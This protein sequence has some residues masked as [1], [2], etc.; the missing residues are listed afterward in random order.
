[1]EKCIALYLR[2]SQADNDLNENDKDESN[3]IENQRALL[4]NY[5]ENR[6]EMD[7][8]IQE[9]IDDGYTGTNFDRPSFKRMIEDAKAGK[10][11][12]ILVKDLSRLG[13]DYIGVG[14][15]LEQI[16]PA[17][18]IR[19][20]AVNSNYDS[21]NFIGNTMGIDTSLT[22][23]MNSLFSKD[24]SKKMK[25]AKTALWKKGIATAGKQPYGY[26]R[27][28]SSPHKWVIDEEA[29]SVVRTI[30]RMAASGLRTKDIVEYLNT[31][32]IPIPA[33]YRMDKYG[34]KQGNIR[35]EELLWNTGGVWRIIRNYS[36]T[37]CAVQGKVETISV[38]SKAG[39]KVPED[40]RYYVAGALPP[41]V[42]V[43][44]FEKAQGAINSQKL[45]GKGSGSGNALTGKIRCGN[46]KLTL[47]YKGKND[48]YLYCQHAAISG[49]KSKCNRD[50]YS[51]PVIENQVRCA[52]NNQIKLLLDL[53][54]QLRK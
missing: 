46:C 54:A 9:Y 8:E 21:N 25:S 33:K 38:G 18:N 13:R 19:F 42:T 35:T 2:L 22:N 48:K 51:A 34:E 29:A 7:G 10:I 16:F 39:R 32:E 4:R 6:P 44:Q 15:Y 49:H 1:M 12:T 52:I 31:N 47:C 37:G 20:I 41:I 53:G 36:Y 24:L 3:S 23:L 50:D 26:V 40:R 43:K 14:D 45:S 30:F 28:Y 5:L 17:L 27:D 11:H